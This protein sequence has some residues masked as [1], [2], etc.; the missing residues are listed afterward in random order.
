MSCN[1]SLS[2]S[3]TETPAPIYIGVIHEIKLDRLLYL[4]FKGNIGFFVGYF[5]KQCLIISCETF[6]IFNF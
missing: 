5:R 2:I 3:P 1:P 6:I 4:I